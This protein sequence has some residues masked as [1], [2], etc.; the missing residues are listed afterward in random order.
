MIAGYEITESL[1]MTAGS[2]LCRA[3]RQEDGVSVL[4][5]VLDLANTSA[6]Q[7]SC[8]QREYAMLRAVAGRGIAQP[9]ALIE[10]QM[11]H[12]MVFS[13]FPGHSLDF[14]LRERRLDLS[15]C[16]ALASQ[17]AAIL[18]DFHAANI[19]HNDI[20][21]LN[22]L[23]SQDMTTIC[24]VDAS[25]ANRH[26]SERA[27]LTAPG[28]MGTELAYISPEQ[29]GR[30]NRLVDYR[31]DFYS[32]GVTLYRMLT[33]TLPF[34]AVEPLEWAH[35]HIARSPTPIKELAPAIPDM[36]SDIVMK[37]L[38][39]GA[40]SRY[41]SAHGLQFD[42][43]VCQSSWNSTGTVAPFGLASADRSEHFQVSPLLYGRE[44]HAALM[45]L[46]LD[47][48]AS[49]GQPELIL[50]SG[51]SG[52]GKS[53]LVLDLYQPV[54]RQ[55]GYFA[56]GKFE[57]YQR[58]TPYR[59]IADAFCQ[60]VQ[61]T[62]SESG[63][64]IEAYRER[65]Q[66]AVGSHGQL[67][68]E[69]IPQ[70][71]L[72]LGPQPKVPELPAFEA[73]LRFQGVFRRFAEVFMSQEQPLVLF[74]DDV[75]WAD[76]ASLGLV[77]YLLTHS[78]TRHL[79]LVGAYRD[80]EVTSGHLLCQ[81]IQTLRDSIPVLDI[82]IGPLP[83]ALLR[84][85]IMDTFH[86]DTATA[87]P[88][89][90][91]IEQKTDGNPFF[92]S[93][94]LR[95]LY[96]DGLASFDLLDRC[97]RWDMADVNAARIT[98]NVVELMASHIGRLHPSLQ[99]LLRLAACLGHQ[100]ELRA[101]ARVAGD[102]PMTIADRLWPAVQQ[103]LLLS[104]QYTG[105]DD[106]PASGLHPV[107]YRW[108]H[109]RVQQSV[110][111]LI[112][113]DACHA[114]HLRIGR[115]LLAETPVSPLAGPLF[116]VV[117]HLNRG[118]V[119]IVDATE[120]Y[121]LAHLNLIA[122]CRAKRATAFSV[123]REH[124]A[125]GKALLGED[126][127]QRDY[128]LA[129]G[130]HRELA[131]AEHLCQCPDD[132]DMAI[133]LALDHARCDPDR[134]ALL[135]LRVVFATGCRDYVSALQVGL[136][137]L[138]LCGV[139]LPSDPAAWGPMANAV[140]SR[141]KP[142]LYLASI[143]ELLER[144]LMTDPTHVAAANLLAQLM[145]AAYACD[146]R[147][148]ALL[149]V[150][151]IEL[152]LQHGHTGASAYAYTWFAVLGQRDKDSY[153]QA[154]RLGTLSRRLID[155][156]QCPEY[157]AKVRSTILLA[158]DVWH[159]P[160][161]TL[162]AALEQELAVGVDYGDV[163]YVGLSIH[164]VALLRLARGGPLAQVAQEIAVARRFAKQSAND[165]AL[166]RLQN[167]DL[168]VTRIR[169]LPPVDVPIELPAQDL[170]LEVVIAAAEL[171]RCVLFGEFEKALPLARRLEPM[172]LHS[173]I[174]AEIGFYPAMV[175]AALYAD[176]EAHD[177]QKSLDLLQSSLE[178][179]TAW[180]IRCPA[181]FVHKQRLLA[182]ELARLSGD[183]GQAMLLYQQAI[184][185]AA[186]YGFM[187]IE[188]LA[189]ERAALACH[190][191]GAPTEA[192]G[193]WYQARAAYLAWGADAKVQQLDA[194]LHRVRDQMPTAIDD[195]LD[196][197]ADRLDFLTV[198][199]ASQA[200]S[201]QI[202]LEALLDTLLRSVIES[203]GAQTCYLLLNRDDAL[204]LAAQARLEQQGMQVHLQPDCA[205]PETLISVAIV[206][207]V[208]RTRQRVLLDDATQPSAFSREPR[209]G[210]QQLK[211]VLCLPILRQTALVGLLY[212]ENNLVTH[213][214][215]P[216]RLAV[217]ELLASQAA[218]SLDNARL[219]N[220]LKLENSERK[221][222]EDE[223]QQYRE[224][225]EQ[226]VE[227]RTTELRHA[228]Q[229]LLQTNNKLSEAHSLLLET[230]Q[231]IR[232]MAQHDVLTGLPNRALLQERIQVGII[233]AQRD[234]SLMIL[235]FIDLDNFKRINDSFGHL[236]GDQLLQIVAKRLKKSVRNG[237]TVARL[238]GDEFVICVTGLM[239]SER[240]AVLAKKVLKGLDTPF[241]IEARKLQ[242][243]G[244]IG[245][246]VYPTDG[247]TAEA[248]MQAADTAM[249][250]AKAKGRG[251]FQ[252]FTPGLT[253]AVQQRVSMESQ[254]RVALLRDE[255]VLHYQP[256][257][258]IASGKIVSAEALIRWNTPERGL[259]GPDEFIP[260]AEETGLILPIGEWVLRQA[261]GQLRRW[262]DMGHRTL[263]IA[264]NLSARQV[265]QPD[266]VE[267]VAAVLR[268]AGLPASALE[269]EITESILMQSDAENIQTLSALASLGV[270]LSL[271]DF[272][273][274][275][276]SLTYL[277][278]F[279]I[280]HSLKID[281]SFVKGVDIDC[282]DKAIA[283]TIITMANS[284]RMQ[285]IAEGVETLEQALFLH[286]N[287]CTLAQ[288][289]YYGHGV[290]THAFTQLLPM[291]LTAPTGKSGPV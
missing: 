288:G 241:S 150:T 125:Q 93:Q 31:T 185:M 60:L 136:D 94:F 46:A 222:V 182:A 35:C 272:G 161:D 81:T 117:S 146:P 70:L 149:T 217:L 13:D 107:A 258:D 40:E 57:Q 109:D 247:T 166:R 78:S 268:E 256:Q 226:L 68:V 203:A 135:M 37:L 168:A 214:F 138:R 124:A 137:A 158:I 202:V 50:V 177:Q 174:A 239:H 180:A 200:I 289:F 223:L 12:V 88:L 157:T 6:N 215:T 201:G 263:G 264:V 176:Q 207:Y 24:L 154:Y 252:F 113:P 179:M 243:G 22:I 209:S 128:A 54:V 240:A 61:H 234:N 104:V 3:V 1:Y 66:T 49:T 196:R 34:E 156:L 112:D 119:L 248:L 230:E 47:R 279:P 43:D 277:K 260:L 27:L 121:Q 218:I 163:Q 133:A 153:D 205:V 282:S 69:L 194:R 2:T 14:L 110:Y 114:M 58:D 130:L 232:Y 67:I 251:N 244:S 283:T 249:Y 186:Q 18:A 187:H 229:E 63:P 221:K 178:K 64:R 193:Y 51:Y 278:R 254:L 83:L 172:R 143:D 169:G 55:R 261:C 120:R 87:Q 184:A 235:L 86:C 262:H 160:L 151:L 53:S 8:F 190:A 255:F 257:V 103:G 276:S 16:L 132:A 197:S 237:D 123:A 126:A 26:S 127:W 56:S 231:R 72:I 280:I 90:A 111:S 75:Q 80:N 225:L 259:I 228:N 246:S 152:S 73:R 23:V 233:E 140:T 92:V 145:T 198:V 41:Q 15:T 142:R 206:N 52:I 99:V 74:L 101:L 165:M 106:V 71:A 147:I 21:P 44:H 227:Q 273:T 242:S 39:K 131:E 270:R 148:F 216:D 167:L 79:L 199:K 265:V 36:V 211:S 102:L 159:E 77:T 84:Q 122:A 134:A 129:L 139:V 175:G 281:R 95:A 208:H 108:S 48:V 291:L 89:A 285:V 266:F 271:D 204:S 192:V 76:A 220:D 30:M 100:F 275:Y 162:V 97:W 170:V 82:R 189:A 173:Y 144:P 98:D 29:T 224:H 213:A 116:E 38:A 188:G 33:G 10:Q 62:L 267:L 195:V 65:L 20:Q 5:K 183:H 96:E 7:S 253:M 9:F 210:T 4:L 32:L 181:N 59:S 11:H 286:A 219:Y 171:R 118:A 19:V 164:I 155:K 290:E 274:G 287:G 269:L 238:G 91:L 245:I 250:H 212:L 85:L 115:L 284:L 17:L 236:V 141:I 105:D 191:V 28:S 45:V 25:R 42:L